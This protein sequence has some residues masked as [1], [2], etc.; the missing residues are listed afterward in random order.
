MA[1]SK[2]L[3]KDNAIDFSALETRWRKTRRNRFTG[4]GYKPH[5]KLYRLL[6]LSQ[7]TLTKLIRKFSP[8]ITY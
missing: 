5:P 1:E 3:N 8:P 6:A 7:V 4:A 2:T